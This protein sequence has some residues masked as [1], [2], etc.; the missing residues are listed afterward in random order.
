MS[1]ARPESRPILDHS[2]LAAC[3]AETPGSHGDTFAVSVAG[4]VGLADYVTA[5]W[6]TPLFR[7]ERLVL[8]L[9]GQPSTDA[10]ARG[11]AE[12]TR[13]H[14]AVWHE[15]TRRNDEL[16][17]EDASR[18]TLSWFHVAPEAGAGRTTLYFGSVVRAVP[19]RG[20]KP[21]LGPV[22]NALLGAHEVYSRLLL[23]SCAARLGRVTSGG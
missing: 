23:G 5:F 18:R 6:C 3:V 22:F 8:R 20:G 1:F 21:T 9:A 14:F 11:L 17:V 16:M 4:A 13:M 10:E 2:L 7:A 12:G 15:Y 19:G